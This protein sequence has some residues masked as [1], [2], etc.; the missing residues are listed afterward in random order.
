MSKGDQSGY[1]YKASQEDWDVIT[2]ENKL[3]SLLSVTENLINIHDLDSLLNMI[4]L[5]ARR[6]TRAEAGSIFLVQGDQLIF[7]FVHNDILFEDQVGLRYRFQNQVLPLDSSSLAGYTAVSGRPLILDDVYCLPPDS[8]CQWNREYDEASGYRTKSMLLSPMRASNGQVVGVLQII[9]AKQDGK[10]VSFRPE[11]LRYLCFFANNATIALERARMTQEMIMRM[12]K[13]SELRD[14]A[15]TGPHV[16]RVGAYCAE[17]YEQWARNQGYGDKEILR[18]KD[19]VRVASMLHDVGKVAISDSILKKPGKL[20]PEEFE[21]IKYHTVFGAQLFGNRV[22]DLDRMA[23]DIALYH[24]EHWNGG[25]YPNLEA[26]REYHLEAPGGEISGKNI[27][28]A[29]R[30]AGLA[31]VYDA[32]ISKRVYKDAWPEERVLQVIRSEEGGQFDPEVV[33]AF[34]EIYDLIKIIREHYQE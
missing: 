26:M 15:E 34:F 8:P 32:L 13:M 20:T 30:M 7:S 1:G 10:V 23:A 3:S 33:K 19:T 5:Q 18:V 11:D 29:A 21:K 27:P 25:G 6:Q 17:I 14:P 2:C 28:I 12:I 16:N 22:S 24:H 9:N 31:D 4:L